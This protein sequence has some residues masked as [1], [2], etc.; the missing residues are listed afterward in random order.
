VVML[1]VL[2]VA[3]IAMVLGR[4][5]CCTTWF[6]KVGASAAWTP[7]NS[8]YLLGMAYIGNQICLPQFQVVQEIAGS[9]FRGVSAPWVG[10]VAVLPSN[11]YR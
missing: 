10:C 9:S 7:I 2:R 1:S 3:L 8:D 4:A 6:K 11:A 5:K